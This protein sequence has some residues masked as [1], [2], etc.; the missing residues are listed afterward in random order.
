M[1]MKRIS[2]SPGKLFEVPAGDDDHAFGLML[3]KSP[4][5]AFYNRQANFDEAGRPTDDPMFIVAVAKSAYSSG[6]WGEPIRQ[7]PNQALPPIP[8]FF[9]QDPI[10]GNCDIF[11]PSGGSD[12]GTS[13]TPEDCIGLERYAV[14]SA[15]H[16]VSRIADTYA[17][18]PNSFA[19]SMRVKF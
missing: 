15:E 14:W 2:F 6:K 10:S 3:E 19:E 4:Y 1:S 9:R 13:A 8:R 17:G 16:V 7:L 5:W 11:D 12:E 18:R